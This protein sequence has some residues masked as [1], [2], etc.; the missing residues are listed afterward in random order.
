MEQ[1]Q[2]ANAG[3]A[4]A[5][6]IGA[7]ALGCFAT[8]YYLVR[9]VKGQDIRNFESGSVGARNVGRMMGMAGFFLTVAGDF[10][11]GVLAVWAADRFTNDPLLPALALLC[12]VAGHIW[13][14]QLFFHGGKGVATSLGALLIYDYRLAVAYAVFFLGGFGLIRKT[15]LPGLFAFACLP[16]T[17]YW[18]HHDNLKLAVIAILAGM[19]LFA[20][21]KNLVEEIPALAAR[22][23]VT[24]KPDHPEL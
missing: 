20:H 13:P 17:D 4:A 22:R 19:I 3:Q 7:Y 1:L 8:G 14:L 23:S 12:V 9:A 24:A 6:A 5:C 11:K 10:G 16:V 18:L 15:I 21:R 2:A